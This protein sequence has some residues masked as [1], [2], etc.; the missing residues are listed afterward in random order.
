MRNITGKK[1]INKNMMTVD[2]ACQSKLAMN[3][4]IINHKKHNLLKGY[5]KVRETISY[6]KNIKL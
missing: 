2:N 5:W 3:E 4:R 6:M 1:K